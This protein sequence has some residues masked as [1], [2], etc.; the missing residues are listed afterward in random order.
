VLGKCV[1]PRGFA[2]IV[3][4]VRWFSAARN[5]PIPDCGAIAGDGAFRQPACFSYLLQDFGRID[6][7]SS[8]AGSVTE[9]R[10]TPTSAKCRS[11]WNCSEDFPFTT[12]RQCA[13]FGGNIG[14]QEASSES[15]RT[16]A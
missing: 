15:S 5:R 1:R 6:D 10:R 7:L 13:R 14:D 8:A 9:L 11:V 4:A 2:R 12:V 3:H 16:S